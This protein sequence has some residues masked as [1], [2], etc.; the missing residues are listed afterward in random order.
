MAG[1][2]IFCDESLKKGK[3]YSNFY[4]GLI[5]EK[6]E[7]ERVKNALISKM[8]DLQMEDSELKWSNVNTFRLEQYIAIIQTFFEFVKSGIVKVRIMF[9]DNR[10]AEVPLQKDYKENRYHLLYYHFLKQAFGLKYII[11]NNPL[12]VEIFFDKLPDNEEKNARFKSFIYQI[13]FLSEFR[14]TQIVIKNDSIYEVD[15]KK[16]ILMQ[17]LDIVLGSIAFRLNNMHKEKQPGTERR[18]NRTVAKEK[19][20]KEIN[21]ILRQIRPNFNIGVSTGIDGQYHNYFH[22]YYRH[23]LFIYTRFT[24]IM[25]GENES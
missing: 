10:F 21:K 4:G 22:H 12:D 5:I 23:W 13:Q 17:C 24:V 15:S 18:G 8:Q 7:F 16:H 6:R 9:T 25:Y 14:Y 19:L 3:Y 1:Y 20:Y 2:Y 11:S